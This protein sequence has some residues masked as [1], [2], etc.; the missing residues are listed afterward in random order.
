MSLQQLTAQAVQLDER[1]QKQEKQVQH[2]ETVTKDAQAALEEL[3]TTGETARMTEH[4]LKINCKNLT[5]ELERLRKE[6]QVFDF[7]NREIQA[8]LKSITR[9]RL[10][11]NRNSKPL[12]SS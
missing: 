7:E 10:G 9:R 11:W 1:L 3:R 2:F 6:Q 12:R 4:E 8:F 5:N